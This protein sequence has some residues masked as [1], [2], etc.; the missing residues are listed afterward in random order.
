MKSLNI[1][2]IGYQFMGRT[3][4]NA[5]RQVGRFFDVPAQPVMKVVCGRDKGGVNAAAAKLGWEE[6]A[7]SW[8]EVVSRPDIDAIDICTPGD[9]HMPIAIAAAEA[10]KAILC[11]KPLAN[12]LEEAERMLAAVKK[13]GVPHML[14]HNY[15]RAPAVALA[16]RLIDDGR[17]GKIH[18]Y[19]GTY[20][21]DWIV[22]PKFPRVWRLEKAKAGSGALGDIGSH[23]LD[24]ARH[25]VGEITEVSGL[26]ETFID[27]RP[28]PEGGGTGKVDVDDAAL[29]LVRFQNG[30]IG[31]IEGT[32]FAP[33]RKNYNR[34]EINGSKGSLA[35]D[36]ERMNE[37]EV[38]EEN[39][40][41]SGFRTILA[42]D[43]SHPYVEA[44][45]PPGHVLGYEHTF[46]HTV[47]DFLGAACGKSPVTPNFEDGVANQRALDA[48]E[49]SAASR[50]WESV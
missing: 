46:T 43:A 35:F 27:E 7:T 50:R 1:A 26:L 41:D 22:D 19:R 31:S 36:L 2:M 39:G 3:H 42:T 40:P 33:G 38:Y 47:L 13:A 29:A 49:R 12:T 32:R 18:H 34:F 15:R 20:L 5:W 10:G 37:L 48:I 30:A 6:S 4:S 9:S 16:K 21:Q 23:S 17:V 8:E 25:L 24:L 45:W 44:W 11:E 14:C 28:L